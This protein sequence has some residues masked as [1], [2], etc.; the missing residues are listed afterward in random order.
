MRG[1]PQFRPHESTKSPKKKQAGQ[2]QFRGIPEPILNAGKDTDRLA[3]VTGY[4]RA[5]AEAALLHW[6]Y[7]AASP[8]SSLSAPPLDIDMEELGASRLK[9][10]A[11]AMNSSGRLEEWMTIKQAHDQSPSVIEQTWIR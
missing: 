7:L 11:K 10:L 6:L 4:L 9:R 3:D 5:T 2:F 8:H 1:S